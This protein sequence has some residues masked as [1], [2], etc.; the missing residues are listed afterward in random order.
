MSLMKPFGFKRFLA[1]CALFHNTEDY[2]DHKILVIQKK[3]TSDNTNLIANISKGNIQILANQS[4]SS[5][6]SRTSKEDLIKAIDISISKV[7]LKDA[8]YVS[9]L[10]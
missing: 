6:T 8:E 10:W 5:T 3:K 2:L 7:P 9:E 1:T 4:E